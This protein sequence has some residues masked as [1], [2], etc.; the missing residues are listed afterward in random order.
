MSKTLLEGIKAA[1]AEKVMK[2]KKVQEEEQ[3]EKDVIDTDK[4]KEKEKDKRDRQGK[5]RS[6]EHRDCQWKRNDMSC[7]P[8]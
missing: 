7:S 2:E 4:A 1:D 3:E 5:D 8:T 6:N